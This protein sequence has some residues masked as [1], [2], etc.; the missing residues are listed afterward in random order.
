M[1]TND[2]YLEYPRVIR[3]CKGTALEDTPWKCVRAKIRGALFT[4]D[5]PFFNGDP[6]GY[7]FAVG[8]LDNKPVFVG[9]SIYSKATGAS[10]RGRP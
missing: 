5:H 9:D 8:V 7:T 6:K 3:M 1:N 10:L 2:L 4:C